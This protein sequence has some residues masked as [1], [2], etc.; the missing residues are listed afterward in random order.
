MK[1][2]GTPFDIDRALNLYIQGII[3]SLALS[4]AVTISTR[5]AEVVR[6]VSGAVCAA[7]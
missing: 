6:H 3:P 2:H 4:Y 5:T 7:V 1:N